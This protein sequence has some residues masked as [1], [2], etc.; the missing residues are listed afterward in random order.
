MSAI[1]ATI[2]PTIN[3]TNV[4]TTKSSCLDKLKTLAV[5]ATSVALAVISLVIIGLAC[6]G[7]S[8]GLAPIFA[9][10]LASSAA[11]LLLL[12]LLKGSLF[13]KQVK[14][15]ETQVQSMESAN[16]QLQDEVAALTQENLKLKETSENLENTHRLLTEFG[17]ELS[18]SNSSLEDIV[19]RFETQIGNLET[20]FTGPMKALKDF[21]NDIRM[22]I[23]PEM[24][25]MASQAKT[26]SHEATT[27]SVHVKLMQR[28]LQEL[29][30]AALTQQ[31]QIKDLKKEKDDLGDI[32]SEM[33]ATIRFLQ[34]KIFDY[35]AKTESTGSQETPAVPVSPVTPETSSSPETPST[36]DDSTK[37][38]QD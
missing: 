21:V 1:T 19:T 37:E 35:V 32:I 14:K 27:L 6:S 31:N 9:L 26:L 30:A 36:Q 23:N 11:I 10:G 16:I 24:E 18:S 28:T 3:N 25:R 33:K 13:A 8:L 2:T 38:Q 17:R 29:E 7:V 34:D 20:S 4:E 5:I 22:V 12:N 15:L